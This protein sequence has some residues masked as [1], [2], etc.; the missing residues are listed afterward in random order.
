MKE[1]ISSALL[2]LYLAILGSYWGLEID[3]FVG[4]LPFFHL[5][6][7]LLFIN[8]FFIPLLPLLFYVCMASIPR[9]WHKRIAH[10]AAFTLSTFYLL[11][12]IFLSLYKSVRRIDFDFYFLWYNREDVLPVIWKI[13]AP[14]IPVIIILAAVLLFVQKNASAYATQ[15][16]RRSSVT[17]WKITTA[18]LACSI[19]CQAVSL[20]T[21]RGSVSGF[22]YAN[23]ISDRK[24]RD[25]YH[26]L[27]TKHI[28]ALGKDL[29][30][31]TARFNP[32]ALGDV[33]FIVKQES[34]NGLLTG[35]EITPQLLRAASD[36]ALIPQLYG[37]SIQSLRGY[38]CILCGVP[39]SAV[40]ALADNY[41]EKELSDLNCLPK[42]FRNLG[43]H[44]LYFFGGSRNPRIV[45][46]A[47]SIGFEKV[48]ADEITLPDDIKFAWG[49]REDVFYS[50]VHQYLETHYTG[51]KLFVFIDTGATNHTPFKVLD[52]TLRDKVPFL[53]PKNFTEN[54]SNT[55]FAQDAYF[56]LLYDLFKQ[57]YGERG[58]LIAVGDHAWPIS[59][60][61]DNI[62]NERGSYEENFLTSLIYIPPATQDTEFDIGAIIPS[63][64]SQMD[65]MPTILDLLGM[66]RPS[67]LGESFAP[68]LLKT[69][70]GE[71]PD[72]E[73]TNLSIQPYGG[74]FISVVQYPRK[75][76]FDVLGGNVNIYDLAQD[77][78]EHSP[79]VHRSNDY[80]HIIHDY[81]QKSNDGIDK[82]LQKSF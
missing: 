13:F 57:D 18:L 54:I 80:L 33:I 73:T 52:A 42:L 68:W 37:N 36:G 5:H 67:L 50:R 19:L 66:E 17:A 78:D 38:E 32:S 27:Y 35:P 43:Y 70:D 10:I 12:I 39:P 72:L 4:D 40:E 81:F 25:D 51:Q 15:W 79:T 64:F 9:L 48:L 41:S 53:H 26:E 76:L 14:W 11:V 8:I 56:G 62:Y 61:K 59:A 28:A 58:T 16:F 2:I 65:I 6:T 46:F 55:T 47:E 3:S 60:H 75:Y 31:P 24:I 29:P 77:P 49:Y 21:V 69:S 1:K 44:T 30:Q 63:R 34:L 20:R 71:K 45:H 82:L 23:F 74:G 7:L 22:I